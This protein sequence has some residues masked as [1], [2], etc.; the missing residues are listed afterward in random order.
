MYMSMLGA[1]SFMNW[2]GGLRT[3][4][5]IFWFATGGILGWPFAAALCAPYMLEEAF[6][7]LFSDKTALIECIMRVA[8]GVVAGLLVLVCCKCGKQWYR[9][10]QS[11]A[12]S[13]LTFSSTS[14]FTRNWPLLAGTLSSTTSFPLL[15]VP[16][17]TEPSRGRFTSRTLLST[18]TS[19]LCWLLSRCRC[20]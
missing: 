11:N 2:R 17:S 4:Y 3:S 16:I 14:S 5:G 15:E 12:A 19:G 6:F 7:S 1:A 13:S 18:S 10:S 8:R 20:F 9:A